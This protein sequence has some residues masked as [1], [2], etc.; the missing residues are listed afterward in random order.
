MPYKDPERHKAYDR[1][2][3]RRL[4]SGAA[5]KAQEAAAGI[6]ARGRTSGTPRKSSTPALPI[7]PSARELLGVLAGQI[8]SLIESRVDPVVRARSVAYLSGVALRA[9]EAT[10]LEERLEALEA[11]IAA[12]NSEFREGRSN[13]TQ[14]TI[15]QSREGACRARDGGGW[16]R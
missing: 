6:A 15:V 7:Q 1:D 4:R 11:Q 5:K 9:V 16:R 2:R 10:D 8:N 14:R 13:A 12:V 3:R